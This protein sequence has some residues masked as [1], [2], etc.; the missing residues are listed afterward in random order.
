MENGNHQK[1]R[2]ITSNNKISPIDGNSSNWDNRHV[3][4]TRQAMYV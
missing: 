3:Q 4:D 2:F 1:F